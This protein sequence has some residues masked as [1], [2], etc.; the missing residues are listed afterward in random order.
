[1][2]L[3]SYT[4]IEAILDW[5]ESPEGQQSLREGDKKE[6]NTPTSGQEALIEEPKTER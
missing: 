4:Q 3:L 1:M 2:A 6:A 5:V